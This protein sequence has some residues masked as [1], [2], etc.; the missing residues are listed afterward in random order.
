[1]SGRG[2]KA[3]Q[4]FPRKPE[5]RVLYEFLD[6]PEAP[7]LASEVKVHVGAPRGYAISPDIALN[8][9]FVSPKVMFFRAVFIV[10]AIR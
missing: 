2:L 10:Y 5:A 1:M 6:L 3:K 7:A 9:S 8:R 4:V